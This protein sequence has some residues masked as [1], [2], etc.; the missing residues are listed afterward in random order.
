M[1]AFK[2][3]IME[4]N[5]RNEELQSRRDFFKKAAKAA[6]PV[7]GAITLS[8]LPGLI[9]AAE[10]ND[11]PSNCQLV[12]SY[13]CSGSCSGGCQGSCGDMCSYGCTQS[14]YSGCLQS[15]TGGCNNTCM[16]GCSSMN[17]F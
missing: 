12:C 2:L 1:A 13:G 8:G 9:K 11:A 15:C 3:N 17:T 14:C 10:T 4:E 16:R 5:K 6:L 7:I